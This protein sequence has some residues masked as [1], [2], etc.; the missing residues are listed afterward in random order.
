MDKWSIPKERYD[1]R[2]VALLPKY[3]L[4]YVFDGN[5]L[6]GWA[7]IWSWVKN[8]GSSA[9]SGAK[10][11]GRDIWKG[12]SYL[13]KKAYQ[14]GAKV[15]EHSSNPIAI[16]SQGANDIGSALESSNA[17]MSIV[18]SSTSLT[19]VSSSIA[20][21]IQQATGSGSWLKSA[22][23]YI[24]KGAGSAL[25][26][27]TSTVAK[28]GGQVAGQLLEAKV[29]KAAGLAGIPQSQAYNQ[30]LGW[31]MRY[32]NQLQ[33]MG[34]PSP[35]AAAASALWANNGMPPPP[36]MSPNTLL[37]TGGAGGGTIESLIKQYW[38]L[39]VGGIALILLLGRKQ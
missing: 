36:D 12:V 37:R 5:G 4:P 20:N 7:D 21:G 17:Q 30:S 39:G 24:V 9:W 32:Q 15:F 33:N 25:N 3:M 8:T 11:I 35:E 27:F 2:L 28:V 31:A 23:S 19:N 26:D 22:T 18:P 34:Y 14:I 6:S 16:A 10:D 13:P 1:P 38:W 29:A